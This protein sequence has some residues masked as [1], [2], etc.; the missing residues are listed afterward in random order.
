VAVLLVEQH[1]E[2]ALGIADRG[3][4]MR[5]GEL[6]AAGAPAHLRA[7]LTSLYRARNGA[8]DMAGGNTPGND[9]SDNSSSSN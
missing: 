1:T 6:V 8:F 4:L 5:R 3:Y 2:R 7:A 9:P